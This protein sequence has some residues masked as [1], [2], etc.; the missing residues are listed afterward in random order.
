MVV[1]YGNSFIYLIQTMSGTV[2]EVGILM[3]KKKRLN[4]I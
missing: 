4:Y 3:L 1:T 2:L